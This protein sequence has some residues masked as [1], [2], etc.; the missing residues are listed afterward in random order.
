MRV[1]V[2]ERERERETY[3]MKQVGLL[4]NPEKDGLTTVYQ[5][6]D[7]SCAVEELCGTWSFKKQ[8]IIN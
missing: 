5:L 3:V 6:I 4:H 8:L 7:I 1:R 2:R